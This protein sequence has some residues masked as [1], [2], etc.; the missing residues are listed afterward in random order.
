MRAVLK[1]EMIGDD[2]FWNNRHGGWSADK[3]LR[4]QRKLGGNKS[5]SWVAR[6]TGKN[7]PILVREFQRGVRDYAA[8]NSTGSRGIFTYYPLS[9]GIYEVNDRRAWGNVRR[10]FIRVEGEAITEISIREVM[11]WLEANTKNI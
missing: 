9:D 7:G 2:Y 8:A 5:P 4:Y 3:S 10:Y 1:L 6:L 11:E